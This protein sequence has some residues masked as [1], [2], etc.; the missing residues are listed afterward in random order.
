MEKFSVK[1]ENFELNASAVFRNLRKEEYFLD[2]T[3]VSD[4]EQLVS[5]HKLVL[6]AASDFFKNILK[7]STHSNPLIYLPGIQSNELFSIMDYIYNGEVQLYKDS[8]DKFLEIAKK[9]KIEGMNS[10]QPKIKEEEKEVEAKF[11]SSVS[12][13]HEFIDVNTD[14]KNGEVKYERHYEKAI[15]LDNQQYSKEQLDRIITDLM[16]KEDGLWKCKTCG[17]V[18]KWGKHMKHHVELHIEG[19]SIQCSQCDSTF[20]CRNSLSKHKHRKHTG[21]MLN[22]Q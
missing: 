5:A 21:S 14:L 17:Y 2:V 13:P 9:L 11:E 8:L 19:L 3:L 16:I 18:S 7:K 20:R 22:A 10:E 1:R 4:D 12:I 15:S 6:S